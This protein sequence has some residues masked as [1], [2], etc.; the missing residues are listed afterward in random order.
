MQAN[1]L[2]FMMLGHLLIVYCSWCET[3]HS[4]INLLSGNTFGSI[5]WS[6]GCS[7]SPMLPDVPLFTR[8]S[9]CR[10]IFSLRRCNTK[11]SDNEDVF[12]L[13]SVAQLDA[14]GLEEA[15]NQK[16]YESEQEEIYLRMR[17]WWALNK[18]PFKSGETED[19]QFDEQ[20]LNNARILLGLL[21]LEEEE[22]LLLI[23]ELHRNTGE[24]EACLKAL[25]GII[26]KRFENQAEQIRQAC[27]AGI[28]TVIRLS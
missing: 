20:Y 14:G 22:N 21:S 23:A 24:P 25:S 7:L 28:R 2:K 4:R 11:E 19:Q 12:D 15:L 16:V 10:C 1:I 5:F 27:I 9:A 26:D 6:D 18:R 17:L 8:C 13:P 3:P